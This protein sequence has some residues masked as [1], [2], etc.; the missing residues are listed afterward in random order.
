MRRQ[1]NQTYAFKQGMEH[2]GRK[3]YDMQQ[4]RG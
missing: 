1:R 4:M 2:N 3:T